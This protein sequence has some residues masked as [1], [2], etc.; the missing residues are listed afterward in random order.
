[1]QTYTDLSEALIKSTQNPVLFISENQ[2]Y[3][4]EVV[5]F[6]AYVKSHVITNKETNEK[7]IFI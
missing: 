7:K 5:F 3:I 1:M 6:R 2:Y 4:L